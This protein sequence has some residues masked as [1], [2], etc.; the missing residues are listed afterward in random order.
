[1][2]PNAKAINEANKVESSRHRRTC[3]AFITPTVKAIE[4]VKELESQ[5]LIKLVRPMDDILEEKSNIKYDINAYCDYHNGKLH[6]TNQR[7]ALKHPI[8]DLMDGRTM[9]IQSEAK[10]QQSD[11]FMEFYPCNFY[12]RGSN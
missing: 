9:P 10:A 6:I 7:L 5:E 8:Q 11:Q 12:Y 2:T 3:R 1:M 4:E